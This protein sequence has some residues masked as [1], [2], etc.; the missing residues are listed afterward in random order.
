[1][2][3]VHPRGGSYALTSRAG[4]KELACGTEMSLSLLLPLHTRLGFP[5]S[6]LAFPKAPVRLLGGREAS[7]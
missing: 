2:W 1:M 3:G 6:L 4:W 5:L 7:A